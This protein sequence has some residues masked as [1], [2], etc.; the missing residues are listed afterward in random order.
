MGFP[1]GFRFD[2]WP[3][4]EP[5]MISRCVDGLVM[6]LAEFDREWLCRHPDAPK[7]Y[8]SGVRYK[9][10]R[11]DVFMDVPAVLKGGGSDC[12][13]LAAWRI[14]ELGLE[15]HEATAMSVWQRADHL[16]FPLIFHVLVLRRDGVIEDPS[17]ALGMEI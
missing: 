5:A 9:R 2:G 16:R 17:V 3:V 4:D 13:N 7:L 1:I 6:A 10:Q 15:G 12:K 14:A 11:R 8:Q